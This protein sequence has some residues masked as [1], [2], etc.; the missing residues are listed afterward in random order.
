MNKKVILMIL[1]GWGL[2]TN[3]EVSAIDQAHTPYVDALY[4]KYKHSTLQASGLYVGLP[5]G[6]M[7]N[8][9]VGHMNLGAGRVVYQDLVKINKAFEENTIAENVA[10]MNA[11]EYAQK[12]NK[13]VHFI[14][15]ASDGGVHAHV[16]HLKGLLTLAAGK[17]LEDVFVHA[18]T[19][20]RDTD[21]KGGYDYLK[22]L[23][24]H[25][26]KTTG[27]I[28]SIVGRY[29]AMDR[30]NRWERVKLAYDVMVNAAGEKTT[31]VLSA[32]EASYQNG[33]TDEFIKPIVNA[34]AEGNPLAKIE[35]HDVVICFNYRTDR[36]REIT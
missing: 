17:G 2:G 4:T 16:D 32:V 31:D 27:Q 33:V 24:E 5:E 14:G 8:S 19:D 12:N 28:A 23:Q 10:L 15:L 13:K 6:Q 18:F 29:Y 3:P 20:G 26:G 7:G 30:D 1:D 34:D 35:P 21:P 22:N 9:E 36:G 11:F 25:M